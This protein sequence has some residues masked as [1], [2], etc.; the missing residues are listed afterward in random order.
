MYYK[1]CTAVDD[2]GKAP[3]YEGEPGYR[4]ALDS[5]GDGVACEWGSTDEEPEEPDDGGGGT[6]PRFST[7]AKAQAAGYGPYY[8]GETEYNWYRDRDGDGVVC[9]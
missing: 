6:D 1:N 7:C 2:A 8:K 9:E 5:D 4:K 3:L